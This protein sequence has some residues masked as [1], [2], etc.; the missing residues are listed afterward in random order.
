[1]S[2]FAKLEVFF[3]LGSG[4]LKSQLYMGKAYADR[5]LHQGC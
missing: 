5:K 2:H 4:A 1:M 3:W